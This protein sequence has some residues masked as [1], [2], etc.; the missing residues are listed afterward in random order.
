MSDLRL[1]KGFLKADLQRAFGSIRFPVAVILVILALLFGIGGDLQGVNNV[2]YMIS[3]A[4]HGMGIMLLLPVA[5]AVYAGSFREDLEHWYMRDIVVRGNQKAYVNTR[6][7]TIFFSAVVVTTVG[8]LI[9]VIA[10]RC[11]MPWV[12]PDDSMCET[13]R[14]EGVFGYFLKQHW[15]LLY[16]LLFGL[17]LGC[18]TGVFALAS[19]VLSL[20]IPN[21]MLVVASPLF[22][23]YFL[24]Q[25]IF[26]LLPIPVMG[27]LDL[28]NLKVEMI[29]NQPL[30][31]LLIMASLTV[32]LFLLLEKVA[33]SRIRRLM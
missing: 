29:N 18:M 27:L 33:Y 19:A 16:Y 15:Y 10:A 9:L 25:F 14:D 20:F 3:L 30:L 26:G 21:R 2:G 4:M 22:I 5:A 28:W 1:K 12:L 7:S 13:M 23:Y 31:S 8:F 11:C 6:C 24:E 17:Q 32:V